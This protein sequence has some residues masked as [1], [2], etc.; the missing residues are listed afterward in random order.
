MLTLFK[1]IV[2]SRIDYGSQLWSPNKKGYISELE[3]IQRC[4]HSVVAWMVPDSTDN[5]H[6]KEKLVTVLAETG[7]TQ[8]QRDL[9]RGQNLLD[10]FC[11]NKPSL[12]KS[13]IS[14]PG[15]SDHSIVI[16]D[17]DLKT[18][19]TNKPQR[20]LYRWSKADWL[21]MNGL[22]TTFAESFL[23]LANSRSVNDNYVVFKK[24][25][26]GLLKTD[27]PSKRSGSRNKLP[28]INT[29]LKRQIR[30]KG[31]RFSKAKK[32]GLK[33]DWDNYKAMEKDVK[34]NLKG[35]KTFCKPF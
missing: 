10:L 22:T 27:I 34:C 21:K 15:I 6:M 35:G 29:E 17:C 9:T 8:M 25:M 18:P 23:A 33:G 24:F 19:I 31:R 13:F 2:L 1:S 12:V 11:C 7:L 3:R 5:R 16:A 4:V 20:R 26:E 32:S 28:W 14:I 30:K